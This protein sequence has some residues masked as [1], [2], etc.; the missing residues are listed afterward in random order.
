MRYAI[1][2]IEDLKN[3]IK[4]CKK[5]NLKYRLEGKLKKVEYDVL[6]KDNCDDIK[7]IGKFM[8]DIGSSV[9]ISFLRDY[10]YKGVFSEENLSFKKITLN[11][12]VTYLE[13]EEVL[14]LDCIALKS[15]LSHKEYDY[16]VLDKV[17]LYVY[18]N[19]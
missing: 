16:F 5:L 2:D 1:V 12:N 18:I 19:N 14:K 4:A 17:E 3:K 8:G 11:D 13:N 6:D 9:E 7:D 15:K 10:T